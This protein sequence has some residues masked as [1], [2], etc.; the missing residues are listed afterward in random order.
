MINIC[1][2]APWFLQLGFGFLALAYLMPGHYVPWPTFEAQTMAALG[3][4]LVVASALFNKPSS[5]GY[6]LGRLG[7]LALALALQPAA[8]WLGGQLPFL[9]DAILPTLYLAAFALCVCAGHAFAATNS[10][11][12]RATLFN[13]LAI[14]AGFSAAITWSQWL[15]QSVLPMTIAVAPWQRPF[16][17][18][19]QPNH[20][21]TLMV[22]G[23]VGTLDAF[24]RRRLGAGVTALVLAFMAGALLMSQSRAGW[25][26]L[27][28]IACWLLWQRKPLGLR[29]GAGW[30]IAFA[31]AFSILSVTWPSLMATMD[32]K[33]FSH[34]ERI[35]EGVRLLHLQ[36][37]VDAAFRKPWLGWG[38]GQV[39][40][41]QLAAAVDHRSSQEQLGYSHNT[42]MDLLLWCGIPVGAAVTAVVVVWFVQ[43]LRAC[44]TPAAAYLLAA[45]IAV[46]VHALLEFPLAHTYFLLPWALIAGMLDGI[47]RRQAVE[48]GLAVASAAEDA[49]ST[50]V[51]AAPAAPSKTHHAP[52]APRR[53]G[54]APRRAWTLPVIPTAAL[55]GL[56]GITTVLTGWVAVEYLRVEG[57]ARAVRFQ[58]AG[59]VGSGATPVPPPDVMLLDELREFHRFIIM[60]A[61]GGM[62]VAQLDW[63]KR[64]MQARPSPP[65]MLRYAVAAGLNDRPQEAANTLATLCKIHL[66]DRCVEGRKAWL[67]AQAQYPE[68]KAVPLPPAPPTPPAARPNLMAARD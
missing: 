40:V 46:G 17:N 28:T 16:G 19:G 51:P 47:R 6:R 11:L 53:A 68:L 38:W 24:Q 26:A 20:L 30:I 44:H 3:A 36:T 31:L 64:V 1:L 45:F 35:Q 13:A 63:M 27:V 41:A 58:L 10:E 34:T 4:I 49:N 7:W 65:V 14:A 8:Q 33:A 22:L 2:A 50:A 29:L 32:L 21:A 48:H 60:T 9:S 39:S 57:S 42:V 59:I 43:H 15:D 25:L 66:Y 67:S 52:F 54:K 61:R 55:A 23:M 18:L 5:D 37:L 12:T 62:T 56:L